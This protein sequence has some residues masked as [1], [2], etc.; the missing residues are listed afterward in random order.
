MEKG[1]PKEGAAACMK[2]KEKDLRRGPD[3]I[4]TKLEKSDEFFVKP[5]FLFYNNNVRIQDPKRR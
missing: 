5:R 2:T 4:E 3:G 1:P